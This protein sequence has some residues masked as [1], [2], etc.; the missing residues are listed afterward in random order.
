MTRP[1]QGSPAGPNSRHQW[2]PAAARARHDLPRLR[3][4]VAAAGFAA[5]AFAASAA[6]VPPTTAPPGLSPQVGS[7]NEQ[8][9]V[10]VAQSVVFDVTNVSLVSVAALHPFALSYRGARLAPGRTVR[11]SARLEEPLAPD[12]VISFRGSD[13]RGGNCADGRLSA[14]TYTEIF[15][16]TGGATAGGCD[17]AW[18]LKFGPRVH[19]A[20]HYSVTVRWQF[21]SV[22]SNG[23]AALSAAVHSGLPPLIPGKKSQPAPPGAAPHSAPIAGPAPTKPPPPPAPP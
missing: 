19:Q 18:T 17:L 3:L 10:S 23:A 21:E 6:P 16:A 9:Q 4:A 15:V 11:I 14:A 8:A 5:T 2:Q 12:S 13:A 22:V 1:G 20:G 7:S